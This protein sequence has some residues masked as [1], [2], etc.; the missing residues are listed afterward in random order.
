MKLFLAF[1]LM[2]LAVVIVG[3]GSLLLGTDKPRAVTGSES[4]TQAKIERLDPAIDQIV[5]AD[6]ILQKVAS[7]FSWTEGP[8]WMQG[9][10]LLFSDIPSYSIRKWTL[11]GLVSVFRKPGG[12]AGSGGVNDF[13]SD[14]NGMTLDRRGRLT[15]AGNTGRDVWRLDSLTSPDQITILADSYHG[16]RLN[17]PNDL[18]Y[19]SDGSLYFTDPPYGLTKEDNDPDKQLLVNGVYRI[20][21]ALHQKAGSPPL[22]AQLQLLVSDLPRPNGLAFSPDEQYLYV[23]NSEPRK[24]WM[25]YRV[26]KDG[27][28]ADGELFFDATSDTRRGLPDGMKVD[29]TGNIYSAGPSGVWILSSVGKHLGTIVIPEEVG[30]LNWGGEEGRTLYITA[31]SSVYRIT[32]RTRGVRP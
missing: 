7:G 6:P 19:R 29:T 14:S 8:I 10:Y 22:R 27:T 15:V 20:P 11:D 16:K 5:P 32:L 24:F 2:I 17:S 4:A 31:S 21:G 1:S 12:Y 18:V 25:R 13:G 26:D 3:T 30:N 28:L 9:D 23:D